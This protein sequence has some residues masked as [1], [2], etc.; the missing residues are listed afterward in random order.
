MYYYVGIFAQIELY[1]GFRNFSDRLK[2]EEFELRIIPRLIAKPIQ[3]LVPKS[4]D[5][6]CLIN[7]GLLT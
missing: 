7:C 6:K 2:D 5:L 3:E 1:L 4:F